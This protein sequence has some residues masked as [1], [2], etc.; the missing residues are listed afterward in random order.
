M[1]NLQ[2]KNSIIILLAFYLVGCSSYVED[3]ASIDFE[4]IIPENMNLPKN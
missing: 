3:R 4:P 2:T 1:N